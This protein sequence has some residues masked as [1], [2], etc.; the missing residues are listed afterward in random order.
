VDDR[1]VS[2]R[3]KRYRH[4]RCHLLCRS[5]ISRAGNLLDLEPVTSLSNRLGRT[6]D[7]LKGR[8]HVGPAGGGE[9]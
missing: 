9:K 2:I 8:W 3:S 1:H 6:I 4:V 7:D 5:D